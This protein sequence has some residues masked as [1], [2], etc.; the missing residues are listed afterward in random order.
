M[1][2]NIPRA[3]WAYI[4]RK[5][6]SSDPLTLLETV[7]YDNLQDYDYLKQ[8][9]QQQYSRTR[10]GLTTVF[11]DLKPKGNQTFIDNSSEV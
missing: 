9:N 8:C 2:D 6:L 4:F 11:Q 3:D 7:P 10:N 1:I 5:Y